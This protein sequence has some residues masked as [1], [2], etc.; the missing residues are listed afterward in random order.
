MREFEEKLIE[1]AAQSASG[2]SQERHDRLMSA[3][4]DVPA[5]PPERALR[6]SMDVRWLGSAVAITL[7]SVA[8]FALFNHRSTS[9]RASRDF[10]APVRVAERSIADAQLALS[11][12]P[13]GPAEPIVRQADDVLKFFVD[14]I[15]VTRSLAA[16]PQEKPRT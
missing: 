14:Q 3:L 4:Q 13:E 10:G 6:A 8:A 5:R 15:S 2:F 9:A 16:R 7:V 1:E 12:L 11:T